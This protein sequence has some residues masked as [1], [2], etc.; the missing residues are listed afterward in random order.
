M[1]A[2]GDSAL[3]RLELWQHAA[4]GRT[5]GAATALLTES[6]E[7]LDPLSGIDLGRVHVAVGIEADLV[8]PM[9]L[10]GFTPA[11][12]EAAQFLQR[13]PLQH[14]HRHV[15]VVADVEAGLLGIGRE[16]HR[17]RRARETVCLYRH[18]L[19]LDEAALARFAARVE[20]F[21]AQ[22]R[23]AAVEDLHRSEERRV[24]KECRGRW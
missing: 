12:P 21:L 8:E 11:P 6:D 5:A 2:G 19:L 4:D 14:V 18:E 3:D 9:E 15:G 23:I 16:I 13:V 22:V 24:G 20:A 7:L 10:T 17:Y 1:S